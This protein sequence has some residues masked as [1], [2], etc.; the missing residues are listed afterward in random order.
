MDTLFDKISRL[1]VSKIYGKPGHAFTPGQTSGAQ[2]RLRQ[3]VY[4]L[5]RTEA[6]INELMQKIDQRQQALAGQEQQLAA[7][8][9]QVDAY[10]LAGNEAAAAAVQQQLN[11]QRQRL[12]KAKTYMLHL[13]TER[14][15]LQKVRD[16]LEVKM[17]IQGLKREVLDDYIRRY[18]Q[19]QTGEPRQTTWR[20]LDPDEA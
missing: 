9:Q 16:R 1:I 2:R 6:Q 5:L 8:D 17:T 14:A 15:R 19:G 18:Q 11:Q 13:H 20:V 12:Q 10:L 3:T 4:D 7:L